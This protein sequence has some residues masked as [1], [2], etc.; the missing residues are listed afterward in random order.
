MALEVEIVSQKPD[1]A[2]CCYEATSTPLVPRSS[3]R[4]S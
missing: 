2:A 4:S 1:G 3:R